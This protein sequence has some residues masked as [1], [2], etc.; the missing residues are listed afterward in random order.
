MHVVLIDNYD[1]FTYNLVHLIEPW[2][3]RLDVYRNDAYPVHA[4]EHAD[5]LVF[6]PGPGLPAEAGGMFGL[7]RQFW[8]LKPMLGVCLGCQAM[9]EISGGSLRNLPQVFHGVATPIEI[10]PNSTLL[11]G[12]QQGH[13]VGRYHSWAIDENTLPDSWLVSARDEDGTVMAIEDETRGV[14]GVQF[15]PESIMTSAGDQ[16]I[17]NWLKSPKPRLR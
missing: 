4:V 15:H 8:G 7:M 6:S 17:Q 11:R 3:D 5:A 10:Q 2:V 16:L 1:S 14:Y 13:R 12:W 9:A